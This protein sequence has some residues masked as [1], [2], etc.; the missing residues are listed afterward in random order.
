MADKS[1]TTRKETDWLGREKEVHFDAR[2]TK[3]GETRFAKDWL[4]RS[5]QEHFDAAGD[6]TGETRRGSD[7]LGRDRAEHFDSK[8]KSTGY[9][10]DG[11]DWLG[12]SVQDHFD[13]PSG[14]RVGRTARTKDWLGRP[15]KTHQGIFHK[16]ATDS[17]PSGSNSGSSRT[18][19]EHSP[20]GRAITSGQMAA[21]FGAIVC[22]ASG[23]HTGYMAANTV[24]AVVCAVVFAVVGAIICWLLLH[25]AIA[26]E[27][28]VIPISVTLGGFYLA[29][30]I[31]KLD[32]A[33]ILAPLQA[34]SKAIDPSEVGDDV[35]CR[36]CGY[37][38][39]VV[40]LSIVESTRRLGPA[41]KA[42]NA[43][44]TGSRQFWEGVTPFKFPWKHDAWIR[45]VAWETQR[46]QTPIGRVDYFRAC[47][48]RNCSAGRL[49]I[50]RDL[51]H[52]DMVVSFTRGD[53]KSSDRATG[54]LEL[55]TLADVIEAAEGEARSAPGLLS[56]L[57]AP[58]VFPMPAAQIELLREAKVL[59]R[60]QP[61]TAKGEAE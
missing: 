41:S 56:V 57:P 9:S 43:V 19:G 35:D 21:S 33:A 32:L 54:S 27:V 45:E 24:G 47:D 22:G 51:D 60:L 1:R 52:H 30:I 42:P 53:G 61:V 16:A 3:V 14:D 13:R 15:L 11:T 59:P 46:L 55:Q 20:P 40:A 7:W 49:R 8:G 6:K 34:K 37:D 38:A 10:K 48:P 28:A 44:V 26:L 23:L 50:L 39:T 31:P 4:G 17:S 29:A 12:G 18:V 25:I 5:K 2:G 58:A 36:E